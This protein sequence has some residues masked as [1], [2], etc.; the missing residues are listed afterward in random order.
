MLSQ[1]RVIFGPEIWSLQNEG[2]ISRYFQELI[3]G[4][5]E[6]GVGGK[7]LTMN[8]SNTRI[9]NLRTLE[10]QIETL[11]GERNVHKE[12]STVLEQEINKNIFHPTY[13]SKHLA[14]YRSPGTRIIVTVHDM[15]SELFPEKRPRLRKK[16]DL[17]KSS[18]RDADHILCVSMHTKN[19]L[20][21]LY[22]TPEEKISE[23]IW[24]QIYICFQ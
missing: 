14:D 1:P 11:K 16:S 4:L 13:F 2:G 24:A 3:Q 5:S 8:N 9:R 23:P 22:G 20:M 10:F 18:I 7:V 21:D 15:I 12:I 19:D 6:K 17:K